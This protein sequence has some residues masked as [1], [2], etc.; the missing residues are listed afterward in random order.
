MHGRTSYLFPLKFLHHIDQLSRKKQPDMIK[1]GIS[2]HLDCILSKNNHSCTVSISDNTFYT[3]YKMNKDNE[4]KQFLK[5]VGGKIRSCRKSLGLSIEEFAEKCD[6]PLH[7]NYVGSVERGEYNISVSALARIAKGLS[8]PI[9]DLLGNK[10]KVPF[11]K[12]DRKKKT[13]ELFQMVENMNHNQMDFL[14]GIAQD[15]L[16]RQLG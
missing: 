12:S 13:T 5:E 2:P 9:E 1:T 16:K 14:I 8:V 6:P 3:V 4:D 11:S 15:I 7:Y 10:T